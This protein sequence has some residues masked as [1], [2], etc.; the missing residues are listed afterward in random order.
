MSVSYTH[1][2]ERREEPHLELLADQRR[3]VPVVLH[4][5]LKPRRRNLKVIRALDRIKLVEQRI[6]RAVHLLAVVDGYPV[7]TVDREAQEILRALLAIL[8]V[9]DLV[10]EPLY[11]RRQRLRD[12]GDDLSRRPL[13]LYRFILH[14]CLPPLYKTSSQQTRVGFVNPLSFI[15]I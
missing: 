8:D 6:Y 4:V 7:R 3:V 14:A 1:L 15:I 12:D 2:L 10:A 11:D 9:P 13:V 5:P